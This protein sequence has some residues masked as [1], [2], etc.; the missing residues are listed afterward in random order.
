MILN[1]ILLFIFVTVLC[2]NIQAQQIDTRSIYYKSAFVQINKML[3]GIDSLDFKKAVFFTE[4]AFYSWTDS[5]PNER[6]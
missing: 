6:K 5:I 2:I 4:D 3:S 1:R